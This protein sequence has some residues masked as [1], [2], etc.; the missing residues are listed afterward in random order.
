MVHDMMMMK[1]AELHTRRCSDQYPLVGLRQSTL[2]SCRDSYRSTL[3]SECVPALVAGIRLARLR[4][5]VRVPERGRSR[6]GC[7]ML[8]LE[9]C[10]SFHRKRLTR[11]RRMERPTMV[12]YLVLSSWDLG[13]PSM[14]MRSASMRR[15][16]LRS[17]IGCSMVDCS[18]SGLIRIGCECCGSCSAGEQG[19]HRNLER[20][21]LRLPA[22]M[23]AWR[24]RMT[25]RRRLV[26][27]QTRNRCS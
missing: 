8:G 14:R 1:L 24:C 15:L 7:L 18:C 19:P 25:G 27:A 22:D 2:G 10:R 17:G 21:S 16:V 5:L 3:G 23:R 12:Y 6:I 20:C 26:V 11:I 9:R 4:M 13:Q